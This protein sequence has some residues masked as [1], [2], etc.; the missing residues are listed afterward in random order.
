M[1]YKNWIRIW[2]LKEIKKLDGKQY[3]KSLRWMGLMLRISIRIIRKIKKIRKRKVIRRIMI[4]WRN[5]LI[6]I[7]IIIIISHN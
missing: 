7:F 2:K 3:L 4:I 1:C 6:I 5:K